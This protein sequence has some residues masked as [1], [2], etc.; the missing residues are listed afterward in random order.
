[1]TSADDHLLYMSVDESELSAVK[2]FLK[3]ALNNKSNR[4]VT[5]I[6]SELE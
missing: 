3:N 2:I 1:M 4:K 6:Y 5:K